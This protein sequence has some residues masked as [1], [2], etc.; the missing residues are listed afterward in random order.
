[1]TAEDEKIR[2]LKR[3]QHLYSPRTMHNGARVE[4]ADGFCKIISLRNTPS[5]GVSSLISIT[6]LELSGCPMDD[7]MM[8]LELV[9]HWWI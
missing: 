7:P 9:S 5:A 8:T 4:V 6:P 1:M 2:G 3:D